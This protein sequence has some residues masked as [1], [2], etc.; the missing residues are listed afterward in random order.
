MSG[1]LMIRIK[2]KIESS[3]PSGN[4]LA[5]GLGWICKTLRTSAKLLAKPLDRSEIF[6]KTFVSFPLVSLVHVLLD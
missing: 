1:Y 2:K 5:G 3:H 6:T 4:N